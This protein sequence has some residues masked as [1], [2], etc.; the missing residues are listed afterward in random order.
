MGEDEATALTSLEVPTMVGVDGR[1]PVMA[2]IENLSAAECRMRS[3]NVFAIGAHIAFELAIHGTPTLVLQGTI[4]SIKQNGPRFS[5]VVSLNGTAPQADA[6]R[7]AVELA[8]KR[9]TRQTADIKTDTGL[10]RSS[11]RVP[12]DLELRYARPGGPPR[13]AR[14]LNISTGGIHM[15]ADDDI[16]VGTQ[17]ELDIPLGT[18]HI[19]VHGRIVAH[20]GASPNY[21]VAFY[22]MTGEAREHLARFIKGQ[23]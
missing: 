23:S 13:T 12:V 10:T 14:A 15:N 11:V 5:Y 6:I 4:G 21:N 3:V 1:S 20:Q 16:P 19:K 7:Q 2:M 22:E 9:V 17:V 18:Q 8:R